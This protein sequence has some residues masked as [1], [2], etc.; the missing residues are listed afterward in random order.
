MLCSVAKDPHHR[1][2][3]RT[4]ANPFLTCTSLRAGS[5]VLMI[6]IGVNLTDKAFASDLDAVLDRAR[7]AGVRHQLITGT[8]IDASRAALALASRY[9]TQLSATAGVHPHYASSC[10]AQSLDTLR[11]LARDPLVRAIGECGLDFFRDISPR[12]VQE[13]W[14]EAQLELGAELALPLFLHERGASLRFLEI[15]RAHRSSFGRGVVHCF[16]GERATLESILELDLHV[17]ITGWICDERRGLSLQEIVSMI[18][19]NRLMVE[20]DAPYLMP[21]TIRPRPKTRRNEPANLP[22]VI[23]Q[24]AESTGR[25]IEEV[26]AQSTATAIDFFDLGD[27]LGDTVK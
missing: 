14:F 18:P 1:G 8:T 4:A 16:T 20:T 11:E 7:D 17:G 19:S 22:F 2:D 6:D 10:N 26:A 27:D 12:P 21:R 25:S 23:A 5:A 24:V 15:I 13:T 9:P 3:L